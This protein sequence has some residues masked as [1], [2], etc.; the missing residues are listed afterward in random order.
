MLRQSGSGRAAGNSD[1]R[2]ED[3]GKTLHQGEV[4]AGKGG[5]EEVDGDGAVVEEVGEEAP[6]FAV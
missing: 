1:Q 3:T 4:E 2:S 6:P 5:A